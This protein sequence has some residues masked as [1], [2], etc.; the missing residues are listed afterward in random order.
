VSLLGAVGTGLLLPVILRYGGRI[1]LWAER[2]LQEGRKVVTGGGLA[3]VPVLVLPVF[4]LTPAEAHASGA[5]AVA[6]IAVAYGLIGLL[7]DMR[8]VGWHIRLG[9]EI[10]LAV[11]AGVLC[12]KL[13][14]LLLP[15]WVL[16]LAGSAN[17]CNMIDNMD[18][19]LAG[20]LGI[21]SAWMF[22][23]GLIS[24]QPA[25]AAMTLC[26]FG[27]CA[28]FLI[29]NRPPALLI[30]GDVGSLS[31]GASVALVAVM[32][33]YYLHPADLTN[34]LI[35]P[36]LM[37][38]PLTD[39]LFVCAYRLRIGQRVF[40][41]NKHQ[42]T[43]FRLATVLGDSRRATYTMWTLQI[44]SGG[45]AVL[46]VA[47]GTLPICFALTVMLFLAMG[48]CLWRVPVIEPVSVAGVPHPATGQPPKAR[49]QETRQPVQP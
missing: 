12:T 19:L 41:G 43:S 45:L 6:L 22:V 23:L 48:V 28:A 18:G 44:I 37:A 27:V 49:Q 10:L 13:P 24:G 36:M 39:T 14:V 5:S 34:L 3:F 15:L 47:T 20:M 16:W 25:L 1:R 33:G 2:D 35:A 31:L 42:H 8:L 4:L 7:D 40:V 9:A 21:A 29:Y 26:L 32:V 30:M 11:V 17:S 38:A 46:G